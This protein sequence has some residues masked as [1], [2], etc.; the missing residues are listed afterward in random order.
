MGIRLLYGLKTADQSYLGVF[1]PSRC[2]GEEAARAGL[3][4]R[5]LIVPRE[6]GSDQ[7]LEFCDGHVVILR[8]E[9]DAEYYG[10]LAQERL[11]SVTR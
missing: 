5:A 11:S 4:Y 7:Y 10:K 8:G 3:D 9:L 1:H 2:L 6:P